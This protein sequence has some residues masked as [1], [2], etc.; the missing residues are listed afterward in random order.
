MEFPAGQGYSGRRRVRGRSQ[1]CGRRQFEKRRRT[2]K[3]TVAVLLG[4][5]ALGVVAYMGKV[6]AQTGARPA[7]APAAA[8]AGP[9]AKIA[10]INLGHVLR[11]YE[12]VKNYNDDLKTT[13]KPF[14]DKENKLKTQ[15][16]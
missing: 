11:N 3:R 1:D 15:L 6:W 12:K 7:G 14:Q 5:L 10:L 9:R 4:V 13:V 2:V 8:A 16:E